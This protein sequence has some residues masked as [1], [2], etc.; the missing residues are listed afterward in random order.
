V[1]NLQKKGNSPLYSIITPSVGNRPKALKQ[2]I[3]S[4]HTALGAAN[5]A[6]DALEMLIGFDG[7]KGE[8]V[9]AP[10][11]VRFF[12][13]PKD[14]DY[15]NA[16]RNTLLKAAKGKKIIFLDDDNVLSDRAL[17]IYM[18]HHEA[19]LIIA[20]IDTSLAFDTPFLPVV[21]EGKE[22]VRHTNIDTLC[23]CADR[24][25]VVDR[26]GGWSSE[27]GYEADFLNIARYYRR[28]KS[29]VVLDDVVGIY[30]AGRGLDSAE[31]SAPQKL[32]DTRSPSEKK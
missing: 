3:D 10:E 15:G 30:D 29:F 23:I 25:L 27:G 32:R 2:A 6:E 4:V 28:A 8:R 17:S 16:V 13:L 1:T 9:P 22:I 21:E 24:E 18:T 12:D 20:R 11:Y 31:R 14:G 26:C 5:L 7:V 19:D